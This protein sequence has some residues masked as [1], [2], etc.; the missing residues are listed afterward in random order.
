MWSEV[1][2]DKSCA[3]EEDGSD[4]GYVKDALGY[5]NTEQ[6]LLPEGEEKSLKNLREW[7]EQIYGWTEERH[8]RNQ[9]EGLET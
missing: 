1:P 3:W 8:H 9:R 4:Q 7:H 2:R 5:H 6:R